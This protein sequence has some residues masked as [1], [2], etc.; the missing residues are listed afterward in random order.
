MAPAN[1]G[2]SSV[3][4]T[5][6]VEVVTT[7]LAVLKQELVVSTT[8]LAPTQPTAPQTA[9][10]AP[11]SPA[12]A[13]QTSAST[14]G[15]GQA[16]T[17]I[18]AQVVASID[19]PAWTLKNVTQEASQFSKHSHEIQH[20]NQDMLQAIVGILSHDPVGPHAGG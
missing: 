10:T 11:S 13:T 4:P 16:F 19:T 6:A 9:A 5:S 2:S 15:S 1:L 14:T 18:S 20:V 12:S 8:Q 17:D 3:T 7:D